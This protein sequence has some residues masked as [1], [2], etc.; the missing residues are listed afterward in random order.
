MEFVRFHFINEDWRALAKTLGVKKSTAYRW[1]KN[2]QNQIPK[3]QRGGKRETKI[4]NQ[5][6]VFMEQYIEENPRITLVQLREKFQNNHQII[7]STEC[8]RT[9]LDGLLYTLKDIRK[10]P[11]RANIESNKIKRRDYVR[12]LLEYQSNNVPIL[13]MD[14]TNFNLYIYQ[15]QK[16]DL[17]KEL[18]ALILQQAVEDPIY[19]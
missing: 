14:E 10:E 4:T 11:E 7:V 5:H 18:V 3:K 17:K 8:L 19:M 6:R 9:H 1:V 13:Y 15:E 12:K 2:H 16:V